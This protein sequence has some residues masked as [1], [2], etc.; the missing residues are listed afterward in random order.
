[1]QTRRSHRSESCF[2]FCDYLLVVGDALTVAS[3]SLPGFHII[4][5]VGEHPNLMLK[6]FTAIQVVSIAGSVGGPN[7]LPENLPISPGGSPSSIRG[8]PQT[9]AFSHFAAF[10]ECFD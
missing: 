9:E 6:V 2:E 10:M 3:C 5:D 7:S 8:Y 1:M 4:D